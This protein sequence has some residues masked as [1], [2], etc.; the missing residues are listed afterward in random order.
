[1]MKVIRQFGYYGRQD[2][3]LMDENTYGALQVFH[4][5]SHPS[6]FK[7]GFSNAAKEGLSLFGKSL[8]IHCF[9]G[10]RIIYTYQNISLK[11]TPNL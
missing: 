8:L 6:V 9:T 11:I 7:A 1:M 10:K 4:R 5:E 2:M 3:M